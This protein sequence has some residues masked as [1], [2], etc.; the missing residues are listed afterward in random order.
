MPHQFFH[1][2]SECLYGVLKCVD[3]G[4]CNAKDLQELQDIGNKCSV[5]Q[6][7]SAAPYCF[8][9]PLSNENIVFKRTTRVDLMNILGDTVL[10]IVDRDT[11]FHAV[12]FPPAQNIHA[13]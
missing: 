13:L 8:R 2:K 7:M 10:H 11:K 1:R 3:S 5:C 4:K 12:V 9:A 6:E